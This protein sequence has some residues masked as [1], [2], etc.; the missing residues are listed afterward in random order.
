MTRSGRPCVSAEKVSDAVAAVTTSYSYPCWNRLKQSLSRG[1]CA[2]SSSRMRTRFEAIAPSFPAI[3]R[4]SGR[5]DICIEGTS[6]ARS[7]GRAEERVPAW[8]RADVVSRER[9][10]GGKFLAC[11]SEVVT[12]ALI[13]RKQRK[14]VVRRGGLAFLRAL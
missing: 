3:A 5:A 11:G 10:A 4:F 2:W 9:R 1:A 13:F 14:A 7:S 6:N 12:S 8:L